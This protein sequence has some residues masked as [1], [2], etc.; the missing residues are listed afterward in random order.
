MWTKTNENKLTPQ[1]IRS[2]N[3]VIWKVIGS[4]FALLILMIVL[5]WFGIFGTLPSFRDLENP[6]SNLAS[7][8]LSED[9][10]PL[11]AYYVQNRS[12][13]VYKDLS[14]NV[15]NALIATED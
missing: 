5:T 11:G 8:I 3:L 15:I 2:Y 4:C 1:D 9:K 14:P 13:V 10:E 12:P 6:K 7:Q